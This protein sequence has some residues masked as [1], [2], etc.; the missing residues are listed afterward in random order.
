VGDGESA[1]RGSCSLYI[2]TGGLVPTVSLEPGTG[3]STLAGTPQ[4]VAVSY[5]LSTI[6]PDGP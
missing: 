2:P 4:R 6:S 1:V 5:Q 3:G